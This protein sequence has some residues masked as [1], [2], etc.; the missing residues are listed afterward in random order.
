MIADGKR[1]CRSILDLPSGHGRVLRFLRAAFPEAEI[2][3][4][5]LLREGVDYCAEAF[6]ATSVYS[7]PEPEKIELPGRYD[8]IWCGSLLT[9]L[10]ESQW[11]GF[12]RLFSSVLEPDGLLVFTT[13][14]KQALK[15]LKSGIHDYSLD[16][17]QRRFMIGEYEARGFGHVA[18]RAERD[19]GTPRKSYGLNFRLRE[20][21]IALNLA[22]YPDE[23]KGYG[24]TFSSPAWTCGKVAEVP[25][26]R[27][28]SFNEHAWDYHQDVVA[29]GLESEPVD[30][31]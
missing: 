19:P 17:G 30:S 21:S 31:F 23:D 1:K 26:L 13:H 5:D 6:G 16:Q 22:S 18:Y 10:P 14:G 27:L 7:R 12:L 3:A 11:G 25:D 9:H 29:C 2:T 24:L 4:C 8:L 15:W 28:V 20:R